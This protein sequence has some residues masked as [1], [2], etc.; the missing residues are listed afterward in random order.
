MRVSSRHVQSMKCCNEISCLGND[1]NYHFKGIFFQFFKVLTSKQSLIFT[2]KL[3][4]L[5]LFHFVCATQNTL[6]HAKEKNDGFMF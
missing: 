3:R 5:W 2:V 6:S 1:D 4:K